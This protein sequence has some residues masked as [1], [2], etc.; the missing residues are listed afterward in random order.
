MIHALVEAVTGGSANDVSA[1]IGHYRSGPKLERFFGA[2]NIQL[3]IGNGSR[4]P[5]VIDVLSKV[6][7]SEPEAIVRVLE[8]VSDPRDFL[9]EPDKHA[10]VVEYLNKRLKFDGYELRANGNLWKL[11]SLGTGSIAAKAFAIAITTLDYSSVEA[12]L[13][14]ALA[15]ADKD[16]EDAITSACSTV[17]SVC[18]CI[19]DD[20]GK[21]Y[22]AKQDIRGLVTE[23][24]KHLN[25]SP[26]REDLPSEWAAD[27]KQVLGG[28]ASVTGG[29]GALRTHAGDAHGR[30]KR[31]TPVD[32]RIA[33]LA[34]HAASTVSLFFIETWNRH[35]GVHDA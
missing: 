4:V 22:P 34:I 13:Q 5:A 18:K 27:V 31:S 16:P 12:D 8:A 20:M 3:R 28:L 1:P 19:L 24:S 17:E 15:Q 32:A 33:R 11:F 30:G 25:L 26:G 9:N 35:K 14:R 29:I 10:A 21:E 2:L 6:N 7:L 23:I